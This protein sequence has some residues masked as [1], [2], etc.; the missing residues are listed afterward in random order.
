[1]KKNT[2]GTSGLIFNE[3]LIFERSVNGRVGYSLPKCDVPESKLDERIPQE[4]LRDDIEGLPEV[5]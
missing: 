2:V 4:Y 1:M 3:P 5:S